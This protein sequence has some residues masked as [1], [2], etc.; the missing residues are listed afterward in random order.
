M[1]SFNFP[2]VVRGEKEV[3]ARAVP[4]RRTGAHCS[5]LIEEDESLGKQWSW[6]GGKERGRER[7]RREE[8]NRKGK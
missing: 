6:G 1:F 2:D 7:E 3:V 4:S 8:E 5:S